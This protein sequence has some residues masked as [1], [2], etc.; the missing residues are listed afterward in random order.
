MLHLEADNMDLDFP[1]STAVLMMFQMF[2][3]FW[4]KG[5]SYLFLILAILDH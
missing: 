4:Y 5:T 1:C 3:K 2:Q